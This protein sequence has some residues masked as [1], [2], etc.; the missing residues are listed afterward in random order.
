[1]LIPAVV[2]PAALLLCVSVL[3]LTGRSPAQGPNFVDDPFAVAAA[4]GKEVVASLVSE[5]S[6][7]QP[8]TTF[9]VALKMVHSG[10][11]HTYWANPGTGRPTQLTW[12]LPE[13]LTA[14][15]IIWP[16]P[17]PKT[18]AIGTSNIYDGTVYLLTDITV[19]DSVSVGS[20][21]SIGLK[22][23]WLQCDEICTPGNHQGKLELA[24]VAEVPAVDDALKQEFDKVR[25]QQPVDS[26]LVDITID[27]Q[28]ESVLVKITP[29]GTMP[30][31]KVHVYHVAKGVLVEPSAAAEK[32]GDSFV[33]AFEKE[34]DAGAVN[35][36]EGFAFAENGWGTDGAIVSIKLP[37]GGVVAD[38]VAPDTALEA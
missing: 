2:R 6:A 18:D 1:M 26:D 14:G 23:N 15:P 33:A 36:L 38:V 4:P 22:A 16:V 12:D 34:K 11:W 3:V 9:T 13:G 32:Q 17:E 8:G 24:V 31:G 37:D 27:D 19:A 10:P 25:L 7:V 35:G 30:E 28:G 5:V 29:T 21:I 20:T